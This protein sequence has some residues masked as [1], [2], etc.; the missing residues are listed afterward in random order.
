MKIIIN[1]K[2]KLEIDLGEFLEEYESAIPID[3]KW[4]LIESFCWMDDVFKKVTD[5]MAR[6]FSRENYNK[7]IH[8]ER[9]KFLKSIQYEEIKYYSDKL[10][11]K[12]EEK[13]RVVNNYWALFHFYHERHQEFGD[14]KEWEPKVNPFDI[15]LRNELSGM[16]EAS[17]EGKLNELPNAN[18][19]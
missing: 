5:M 1:E 2:G 16:I 19:E 18:R 14:M 12:I 6:E 15:D 10:A 4:K 13:F 3:E 11:S 8:V 9:E 7:F 17:F